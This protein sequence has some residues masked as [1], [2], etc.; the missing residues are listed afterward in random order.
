MTIEAFVF[1]RLLLL[2]ASLPHSLLTNKRRPA[3]SFYFV[4]ICLLPCMASPS[5]TY[6]RIRKYVA[7]TAV[8]L[9]KHGKH[10]LV[11]V[12]NL[13]VEIDSRC[14]SLVLSFLNYD[15]RP[16]KGCNALDSALFL[17]VDSARTLHSQPARS[18]HS[19]FDSHL[20]LFYFPSECNHFWASSFLLAQQTTECEY[21][22][23]Y[24]QGQQR[25]EKRENFGLGL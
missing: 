17:E 25:G 7:L 6:V 1:F 18:L 13:A 2:S 4:F 15:M 24:Q 9:L 14:M 21:I 12:H 16:L 10:Y 11:V 5:Y 8:C 23:V 22:H 19:L 20:F 3:F